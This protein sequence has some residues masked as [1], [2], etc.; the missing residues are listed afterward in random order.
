MKTLILETS[1][2][3]SCLLASEGEEI[4]E[5]LFL[6]GGPALSKKI[7]LDVSLLLKRL[8]WIPEKIAVGQGPGSF[9]GIRVGASLA[10]ALAFGWGIPLLGFC[11]LRAFAPASPE[12]YAVLFDAK[13]GGVYV[14]LPGQEAALLSLE[15]AQQALAAIPFLASPHP[16]LIQKRL[17]LPG[18]WIETAPSPALLVKIAAEAPL[19]P[20]KLEYSS[21]WFL[22]RKPSLRI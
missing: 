7:G 6:E 1:T 13:M 2:E 3:K 22:D 12:P 10:K 21:N 20:L 16:L 19:S 15:A 8:G 14:W 11:S 4:I 18:R 17:T 5:A 9:T